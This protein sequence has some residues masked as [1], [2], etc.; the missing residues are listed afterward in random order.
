MSDRFYSLDDILNEYQKKDGEPSASKSH[1]IIP[2]FS[3]KL[4][5]RTISGTG[6]IRAVIPVLKINT[7]S[8]PQRRARLQK[9]KARF[10]KK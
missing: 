6:K 10:R 4:R 1:S 2:I 8:F 5:N 9:E 7:V 3:E